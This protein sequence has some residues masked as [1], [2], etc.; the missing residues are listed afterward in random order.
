MLH[1]KA[2]N[3]DDEAFKKQ[4]VVTVATDVA[5]FASDIQQSDDPF[6]VAQRREPERISTPLE[7]KYT[8][9]PEPK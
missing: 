4:S 1:A 3:I 9:A 7:Y 6:P 8:K 5:G 2:P